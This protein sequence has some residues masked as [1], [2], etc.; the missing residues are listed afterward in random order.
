MPIAFSH[1]RTRWFG[2]DAIG[3]WQH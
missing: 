1:S 3:W 2:N